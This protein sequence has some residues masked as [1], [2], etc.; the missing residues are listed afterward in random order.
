MRHRGQVS[1]IAIVKAEIDT[2]GEL[3]YTVYTDNGEVVIVATQVMKIRDARAKLRDVLDA[4]QS[5]QTDTII[6]RNGK[7]VAVVIPH[8]DY[9][10]LKEELQDLRDA[11]LALPEL[12]AWRADPTLGRTYADIRAELVKD[13]LLDE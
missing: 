2:P 6:E 1:D 4:A 3:R 11:R 13:G 7:P 12:E 10:A 8:A 9:L 5:G